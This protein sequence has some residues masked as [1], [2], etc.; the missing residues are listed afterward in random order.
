[1]C[2]CS[3]GAGFVRTQIPILVLRAFMG[4][5]ARVWLSIVHCFDTDPAHTSGKCCTYRSVGN[6][7]CHAPIPRAS[8]T[9]QGCGFIWSV[10]GIW[11]W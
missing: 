6:E 11:C 5:G 3:L 2:F 8:R 4:V 9:G 1:M 10:I 7:P